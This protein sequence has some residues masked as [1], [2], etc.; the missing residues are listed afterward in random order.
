MKKYFKS[1]QMLV[2]MVGFITAALMLMGAGID[3]ALMNYNRQ[4]MQAAV[5]SAAMAAAR[6][7][8][9]VA[10]MNEMAAANGYVDGVDGVSITFQ[11]NPDGLHDN[12][13]RV[14]ISKTHN[15]AFGRLLG[16]NTV[17]LVAEAT[18]QANTTIPLSITMG[19]LYGEENPPV[20]LVIDGP[21]GQYADGDL[22]SIARKPDGTPNEYY[23]PDGYD[24]KLYVP[25]G[26]NNTNGNQLF[27]E[28]FD[29]EDWNGTYDG[30]SG[31]TRG[32]TVYS[33][34]APDNTPSVK[35]DDTLIASY[36]AAPSNHTYNNKWYSPSGWNVNLLTHGTGAYRINV[37]TLN[38]SS[39]GNG[40]HLRAGP[41][42]ETG[43]A[44][45][46]NNGTKIASDGPL[47]IR[48]NQNATAAGMCLGFVPTQ[49][50]G[51]KLRITKFDTDIGSVSCRYTCDSMPGYSWPGKLAGNGEIVED[52][53]TLPAS[54]TGGLWFVDYIAGTNDISCWWMSYD[55]ISGEASD[56]SSKIF[57]VE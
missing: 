20:T 8:P 54:Y 33:I 48:F 51:K 44:F 4:T 27:V 29:P 32:T 5:D 22:F 49:V 1:G 39:N 53:I 55:G 16:R 56:Q 47:P 6:N 31:R 42:R 11:Q 34:Y 15:L 35:T 14:R 7:M 10:R 50:A 36:T 30:P 41:V 25:S 43:V 17:T 9:N 26:W 52:E 2:L 38:G 3:I 37:K 13:I 46:P 18:A 28:I 23:K 19:S 40:F 12:W 45:N 24:Y 57:L 21:N